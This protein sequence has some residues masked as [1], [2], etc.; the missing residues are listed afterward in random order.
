MTTQLTG[1]IFASRPQ[2][3]LRRIPDC[4]GLGPP[5]YSQSIALNITARVPIYESRRQAP[6]RRFDFFPG[7]V[8]GIPGVVP[9]S[10]MM[11]ATTWF[12][13]QPLRYNQA[14]MRSQDNQGVNSGILSI[15]ATFKNVTEAASALETIT[16]AGQFNATMSEAAA[17]SDT[18]GVAQATSNVVAD[19]LSAA[20]TD[21]ANVG[22]LVSITDASLFASD[23]V[24]AART[25]S[26][27]LTDTTTG[28]DSQ[29]SVAGF[30]PAINDTTA[31]AA[32]TTNGQRQ[33]PVAEA[34]NAVDIN[35]PTSQLA[36]AVVEAGAGVDTP[37]ASVAF[38]KSIVEAGAAV[39][40]S[41]ASRGTTNPVAEVASAADTVNGVDVPR[42]FIYENSFAW[43][44]PNRPTFTVVLP[45]TTP[46]QTM[47]LSKR[48]YD[49]RP[50]D[51]VVT[52]LLSPGATVGS[53]NSVSAD[54][55][56][57]VFGTPVVNTQQNIYPDGTIAPIGNVIQ[58]PISGGTI[59]P[60]LSQLMCTIRVQFTDTNGALI[61]ATV[62]LLLINEVIA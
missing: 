30:A 40:I 50:Y 33:A 51:V 8:Y 12:A 9:P 46:M 25:L 13:Q 6:M 29:T 47:I 44:P 56:G 20:D 62:L 1:A 41:T 49:A 43:E 18:V 38:S 58:I 53:V 26:G 4:V 31:S 23:I 21:V 27:I 15:A 32:D 60:L 10:T 35:T 17:A 45:G 52:N 59:P 2:A 54:Q 55:G 7:R 14:A 28:L 11:P 16:V 42:G 39:D 57:L 48:T 61:E 34:A 19:A 37:T 24:G 3:P 36:V 5:Q 22:G